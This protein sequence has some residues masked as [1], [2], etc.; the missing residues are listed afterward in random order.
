MYYSDKVF[1]LKDCGEEALELLVAFEKGAVYIDYDMISFNFDK[2]EVY[3]DEKMEAI[4]DYE[5]FK[6]FWQYS[7]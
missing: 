3:S 2:L 5:E 4:D 1:C 7:E 6:V